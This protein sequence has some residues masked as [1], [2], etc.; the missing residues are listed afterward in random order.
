MRKRRVAFAAVCGW[1]VAGILVAGDQITHDA[2]IWCDDEIVDN[3]DVETLL[4]NWGPC[5]VPP[6]DPPTTCPGDLNENGFVGETD[7][8][9][10]LAHWGPCAVPGDVDGNGSATVLDLQI[11]LLD[12]LLVN[13]P[14]CQADLDYNG[15]V[16]GNDYALAELEWTRVG[17]SDDEHHEE[18]AEVDGNPTLGVADVLQVL[19]ASGEDCRSDVNHDGVIDNA[20]AQCVC[21]YLGYTEEQCLDL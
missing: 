11:V 7:L 14:N 1:L 10:V 16:D 2:E 13:G 9:I 15:R 21:L 17:N 19:E 4:G 20:D 12:A 8:R 5:V 18:V 3:F 6:T